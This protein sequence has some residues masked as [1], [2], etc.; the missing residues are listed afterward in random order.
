MDEVKIRLTT[1]SHGAGCGCK[2]SPELLAGVLRDLPPVVDTNVLVGL[3]TS[4]DA[5]VYKISDDVAVVLTVDYFTPIVDDAY[6]FGRIAAA[7][8]LSDAYA[9]GATPVVAL[10]LVGFPA[11]TL[12]LSLLKEILR[13]GSDI[14]QEAGVSVVGGHSIDDPEPKYGMVVL[15][16]IN[17]KQVMTNAAAKPGDVLFLTK[18][19]GMGVIS[20][21]MKNG[22]APDDLV[23]TAV[24]L[25]TT[26]NKAA[27]KAALSV[28]VNACTDVTGFSLLGH[29]REMVY[30]SGVG[31]II[32]LS[33]A[34]VIPGVSDLLKQD[35]SP[36][37]AY[38][39]I[40]FLENCG[41]VEWGLGTTQ[42]EKL[43][44]C[45]PQTSGGLLIS[46]PAER[47]DAMEKQLQVPG[48]P[49]AA[50]IGEIVTDV[51]KKIRVRR[52]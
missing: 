12:P 22:V 2:L 9:M 52:S 41:A 4:D 13:G 17:P 47:A 18:P 49:V 36:G 35:M 32:D 28:G 21:A 34:P 25:M 31:A 50:R 43:L 19:L 3:A 14:A 45:D 37:G 8:A 6:D 20:T 26:L 38:R 30:A 16:V 48:V 1:L 23:R 46:V 33:A 51:E 5:A 44:L 42:E 15:G 40:Q 11:K 24:S 27:A 29:L 7:N 10:N 39:N